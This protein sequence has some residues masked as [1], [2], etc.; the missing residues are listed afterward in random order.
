MHPT[1][2]TIDNMHPQFM[3]CTAPYRHAIFYR[4]PKAKSF[5]VHNASIT[6]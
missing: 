3:I 6:I 5:V 1:L 2:E 4:R